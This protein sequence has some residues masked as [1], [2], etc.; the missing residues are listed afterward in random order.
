MGQQRERQTEKTK[1]KGTFAV[2]RWVSGVQGSELADAAA[3][4]G[5]QG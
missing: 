2:Q 1:A 5:H 3:V 4:S